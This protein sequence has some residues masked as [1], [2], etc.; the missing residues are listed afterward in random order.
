VSARRGFPGKR[1]TG[2]TVSAAA[3]VAGLA[4]A[5]AAHAAPFDADSA[6]AKAHALT[7]HVAR[8]E[9]AP[10]W[11][12]FDENMRAALKD[13]ASFAATLRQI[14][15]TTGALDSLLTESVSS[16][17]AGVFVYQAT[18]R[19]AKSATPLELIFAFDATG[20]VSGMLVRPPAGAPRKEYPSAFL[21]YRAKTRLR[22][23][24]RGEW[25]VFWGG[26]TLGQNYHAF[27][28]DQRFALDVLIVRNGRTHDGDGKRCS[29]YYCYGQP[30]LAPAAGTIVWAQDSLPDQVP[31]QMDPAH[32]TGNSLIIDHGNGEYSLIAHLQAGSMRCKVGEHVPADAELGR[33]GNSGNT[34]EPH[35]HYHLQNGPAP[36][37][38][39]GLPIEFVKLV[40]DDKPLDRAEIV[41]GQ[42]ARRQP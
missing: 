21:D 5:V 3:L 37:D 34:T 36:F 23:P 4:A 24:F 39:D 38:A 10:L 18:C 9:D 1:R 30:V 19:F 42:R 17:Q 40:V 22:L 14:A 26:R 28:R 6:R 20:R 32:A 15:G 27:T 13:S 12:E 16:P 41:K 11:R 35:I 7:P 25:T 33:C 2:G 29:D 8:S 31:G